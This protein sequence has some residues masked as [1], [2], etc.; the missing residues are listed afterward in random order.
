M[1][2]LSQRIVFFLVSEHSYFN[3]DSTNLGNLLAS[4]FPSCSQPA[5]GRG[6]VR[7]TVKTCGEDYLS[8]QRWRLP[9]GYMHGV[10]KA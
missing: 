2:L 9:C 3:V 10:P 1:L 8:T 5:E 6:L 4:F 7:L